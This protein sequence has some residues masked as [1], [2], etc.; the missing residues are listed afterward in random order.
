MATIYWQVRPELTQLA[1][2]GRFGRQVEIN[3]VAESDII[4]K[5]TEVKIVFDDN[6]QGW[7]RLD[8]INVVQVIENPEYA[9]LY[10]ELE[11]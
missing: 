10:S 4:G 9:N 2:A 5:H 11:V 7:Y 8:E 6:T 1:H 3:P